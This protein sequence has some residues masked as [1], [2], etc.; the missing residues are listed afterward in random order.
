MPMHA[1]VL[2]LL[3]L[4]VADSADSANPA[5]LA[6]AAAAAASS[7]TLAGLRA[8]I[9]SRLPLLPMLRRRLHATPLNLSNP[10]WVDANPDLEA[11][12]VAVQL[13]ADAS[14]A[15]LEARVAL[16]HAQL[17]ERSRPL[18][19]FTLFEGLAP[20]PAGQ[21]R[22]ALY[23]QLH[24]AALGGQAAAALAE[25]L[26]DPSSQPRELRLPPAQAQQVAR[27][28]AGVVGQLSSALAQQWQQTLQMAKALPVAASTLGALAAKTAAG[29]AGNTLQ[30]WL[31]EARGEAPV[32]RVSQVALAP[33]TRLNVS[34]SAQRSFS[35]VSL[36][37]AELNRLRRLH[38][39]SL[40]EALLFICAGALRRYFVKH[41]PLPSSSLVA[42]LP[43]SVSAAESTVGAADAGTQASISLLSLGT[44]LADPARR[45][46]HLLSASA[47]AKRQRATVE[48]LLPSDFPSL[49]LPWLL[50]AGAVLYGRL[51][52][53]E[54]LPAL[55]NLLI[56]IVPGG[57]PGPGHRMPR[58]LA[59]ARLLANY[60][61]AS[62]VHG[63][64]LHISAQS[65]ADTLDI[66]LLA[67]GQALPETAELAAYV[68][69][70]FL[71]FQLLS[72]AKPLPIRKPGRSTAVAL[73]SAKKRT[74]TKPGPG[75]G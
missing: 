34:L 56:S 25:V 71:E 17:L 60:P 37:L 7:D 22:V 23:T 41:G 52:A 18:W 36:P 40:D 50:Q 33:R 30:D 8:H 38:R 1:G 61:V 70:A 24:Q 27:L 44:Q 32:E 6:A 49:G 47:T 55:A 5:E 73:K 3:E 15:V 10:G 64:A 14:M 13:P 51:H 21:R 58:Y 72:M 20:G 16:L 75:S 62:I 48:A 53:A 46:A 67:C 45:L 74:G 35:T 9:A 31:A 29:L 26:L 2:Y 28:P 66:G 12:I 59:G 65:T 39:A 4:P 63:L 57:G 69:T 11:H 68:E 42:A 19:K 43:V 54:K